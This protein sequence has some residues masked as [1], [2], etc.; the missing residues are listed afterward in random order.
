MSLRQYTTS[1]PMIAVGRTLPRYKT[2]EGT[3]LLNIINGKNLVRVVTEAI[4]IMRVML[5]ILSLRI[6]LIDRKNE[7]Y[8]NHRWYQEVF[9]TKDN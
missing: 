7:C 5:C 6:Y 1:I 4:I 8:K 9:F 3:F 2:K